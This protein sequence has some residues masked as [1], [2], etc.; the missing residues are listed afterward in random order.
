MA[1]KV[2]LDVNGEQVFPNPTCW[3]ARCGHMFDDHRDEDD[4]DQLAGC[5]V[6]DQVEHIED[7][8]CPEFAPRPKEQKIQVYLLPQ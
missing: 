7:C 2:W 1:A 4:G 6:F 3:C 8:D 5:F